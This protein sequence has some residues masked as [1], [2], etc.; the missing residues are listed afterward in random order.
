MW[1][2]L[3][4]AAPR[5]V[6]APGPAKL[7]ENPRGRSAL[8]RYGLPPSASALLPQGKWLFLTWHLHGSLPHALYPPVHKLSGEAFVWMDRYLDTTRIGPRYLGRPELA[9]VVVECLKRGV[10]LGHYELRA[11]VIMANHVHVVL[12]PKV[13]PARLLQPL[14]GVTAR[15]A[16]RFLGRTGESFWQRESYDPLGQG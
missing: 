7:D 2:T 10:A 6:S 11:Y 4:R 14:K 3:Q 8:N 9:E 1:R 12:L 5:I 13:A 16:N 15:E